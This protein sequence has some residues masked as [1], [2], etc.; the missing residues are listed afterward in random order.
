M[1]YSFWHADTIIS[2]TPK[3]VADS[4]T[5]RTESSVERAARRDEVDAFLRAIVGR[6]VR[7]A[8]SG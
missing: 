6:L 3:N 5:E 2:V 7:V 1:H 8:S 4:T